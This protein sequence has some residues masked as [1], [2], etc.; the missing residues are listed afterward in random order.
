M[1]TSKEI[2][3]PNL[4]FNTNGSDKYL[5]TDGFPWAI[6]VPSKWN[7]PY[8][9]KYISLGYPCFD[10]WYLSGGVDYQDWFLRTST[11]SIN[12][13]FPYYNDIEYQDIEGCQ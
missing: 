3:F 8:E 6:L 10:E 11:S 2:H 13:V 9:R 7:W 12:N 5:D 4:Y 1:N